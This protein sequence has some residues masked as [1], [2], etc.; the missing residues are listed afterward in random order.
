[1]DGVGGRSAR[2]MKRNGH[3]TKDKGES[4]G[5]REIEKEGKA[6]GET[7]DEPIKKFDRSKAADS[8]SH[9]TF[10]SRL[11]PT[12][13]GSIFQFHRSRGFGLMDEA[14]GVLKVGEEKEKGT[15]GPK[16]REWKDEREWGWRR[17]K[18]SGNERKEEAGLVG[19]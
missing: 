2:L 16:G 6:V 11:L 12:K 14:G 7:R 9:P 3:E 13:S 19:G 4:K 10:P 18:S 8:S 15:M 5:L 17:K 1:M